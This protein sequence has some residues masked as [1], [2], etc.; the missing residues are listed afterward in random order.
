MN[1]VN[2]RKEFF[3][4]PVAI[5]KGELKYLGITAQWTMAAEAAE[6]RETLAIERALKEDPTE[7]QRWLESNPPYDSR[8]SFLKEE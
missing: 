5:I 7:G 2:P 8:E 3:R 4:V 6:Y 1:K